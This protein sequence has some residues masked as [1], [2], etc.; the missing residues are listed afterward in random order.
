MAHSGKFSICNIFNNYKYYWIL[1]NDYIKLVPDDYFKGKKDEIIR[2][3]KEKATFDLTDFLMD[4]TILKDTEQFTSSYPRSSNRRK[5]YKYY[6]SLDKTYKIDKNK[7]VKN[8]SLKED[9]LD[10]FEVDSS[11]IIDYIEIYDKNNN[12]IRIPAG[13]GFISNF[14]LKQI[15]FFHNNKLIKTLVEVY[16]LIAD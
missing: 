8:S 16:N 15:K 10:N 11:T 4:T 14:K 5:T 13:I 2:K 12:S 9:F 3:R 1:E 6:E 7:L